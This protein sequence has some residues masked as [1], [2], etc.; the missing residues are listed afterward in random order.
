MNLEQPSSLFLEQTFFFFFLPFLNSLFQ[1]RFGS[2]LTPNEKPKVYK[3][4]TKQHCCKISPMFR[5]TNTCM[6][7]QNTNSLDPIP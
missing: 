2:H 7:T 3:E 1:Y 6:C 4:I 5:K